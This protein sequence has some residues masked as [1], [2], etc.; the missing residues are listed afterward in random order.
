M[1]FNRSKSVTTIKKI[2]KKKRNKDNQDYEVTTIKTDK[3]GKRQVSKEIRNR[4]QEFNL[5]NNSID[6]I[7]LIKSNSS[8]QFEKIKKLKSDDPYQYKSLDRDLK[9]DYNI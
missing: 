9:K 6:M 5:L 1:P 3:N 8:K 7:E 2:I 4:P